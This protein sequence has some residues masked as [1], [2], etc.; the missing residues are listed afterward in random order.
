MRLLLTRPAAEGERSRQAFAAAGHEVLLAPVLAIEALPAPLDLT[1]IQALAVT[2]RQGAA[3]LAQATPRRDLPVY[4]VGDATAERARAAGFAVV[5]S[6]GG[7]VHDLARRLAAGIDPAAGGVLQA[8]GERVARDL[9]ELLRPSGIRVV[10]TTLYRARALAALDRTAVAALQGGKLDGVVFF[11]P[12]SARV[13]ARLAV[14]QGID[15]A[16]GRLLAVCLSPAVAVAA[17]GLAWREAL[18]AARPDLASLLAA[19]AAYAGHTDGR[20]EAR[21]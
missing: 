7:D 8:A 10:R 9:G 5:H 15:A 17:A 16:C 13:F 4:A 1:G 21:Q 19:L 14:R 6:A 2:S 12:R 18:V 11:S 3:A 20:T